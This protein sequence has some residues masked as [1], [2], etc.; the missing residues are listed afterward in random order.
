MNIQLFSAKK[1]SFV[2]YWISTFIA[3]YSCDFREMM[4]FHLMI[5]TGLEV[6][7]PQWRTAEVRKVVRLMEI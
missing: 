4:K 2:V 5:R 6:E 1:A 7:K 3:R